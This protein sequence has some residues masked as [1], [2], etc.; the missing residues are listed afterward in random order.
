MGRWTTRLHALVGAETEECASLGHRQNR[1]NPPIISSV[2]FVGGPLARKSSVPNPAI[3]GSERFPCEQPFLGRPLLISPVSLPAIDVHAV[4]TAASRGI[5]SL[6]A[7][8]YLALLS[9]DDIEGI[10]AGETTEETLRAYAPLFA[11][12]I[13]SGR[14]KIPKRDESALVRCGA[15]Q[16]FI[17][18]QINPPG[19]M[20][21]CAVNGE[22]SRK[23][24]IHPFT[25]THCKD[26][27]TTDSVL[28]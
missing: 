10:K 22:S 16:H 9:T 6:A 8:E 4:V 25:Q 17:R 13:A 28:S 7:D 15:C 26:F 24:L 3:P 19:G 18:D 27:R 12:G 1:Q 2:S 5:P 20:G 21:D 14:L 23:S 11:E